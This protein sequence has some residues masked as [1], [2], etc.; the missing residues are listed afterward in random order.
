MLTL[1]YDQK[2]TCASL[3]VMVMQNPTKFKN[4]SVTGVVASKC[5]RH[6]MFLHKSMADLQ[7]GERY[8][9]VPI[10]NRYSN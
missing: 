2:S 9:P 7:R 4:M 1:E 10:G 6:D 3:N 5:G 8:V